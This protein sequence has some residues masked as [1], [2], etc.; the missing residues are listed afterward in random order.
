MANTTATKNLSQDRRRLAHFAAGTIA[1]MV[2]EQNVPVP[3]SADGSGIRSKYKSQV[4][5]CR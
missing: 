2:A 1:A 3:F 4:R 5:G